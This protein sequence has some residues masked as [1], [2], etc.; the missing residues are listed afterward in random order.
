MA[1][2]SGFQTLSRRFFDDLNLDDVGKQTVIF[3]NSLICMRTHKVHAARWPSS[4][5]LPS[6]HLPLAFKRAHPNMLCHFATSQLPDYL[7]MSREYSSIKAPMPVYS[8]NPISVMHSHYDR[9]HVEALM[10]KSS[11]MIYEQIH[12][13]TV[14]TENFL[15]KRTFS[16]TTAY[17]PDIIQKSH[18]TYFWTKQIASICCQ[19]HATVQYH[20]FHAMVFSIARTYLFL[21]NSCAKKWTDLIY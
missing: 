3:Q 9:W 12:Y 14:P 10:I 21:H 5:H 13:V 19:C 8:K 6:R 2:L 17:C 11:L 7:F 20:Q 18:R 15:T 16:M 1:Q 4:G